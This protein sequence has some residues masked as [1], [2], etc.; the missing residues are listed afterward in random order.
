MPIR[1]KNLE[2][3]TLIGA[4]A[5]VTILAAP[6][7]VSMSPLGACASVVTGVASAI[8]LADISLVAANLRQMVHS[9]NVWTAY[10]VSSS[11]LKNTLLADCLFSRRIEKCWGNRIGL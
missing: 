1:A 4:V 11:L 9:N 8:S 2:T 3:G 6:L 5:S 7:V 10:V